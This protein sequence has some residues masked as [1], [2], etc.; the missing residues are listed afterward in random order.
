MPLLLLLT[1]L[2]LSLITDGARSLSN[3]DT[4][5]FLNTFDPATPGLAQLR[6]RL[7]GAA[8]DTQVTG[9]EFVR[10]VETPGSADLEMNWQ[11]RIVR[12]QGA[13]AT[14]DLRPRVKCRIALR[15]GGMRIVAFE[16][17]DLF[18]APDVSGAWAAVASAA[19]ALDAPEV[20]T[21]STSSSR[22]LG[23]VQLFDP[24]MPGFDQL[25]N[26]VAGLLAR[27]DVDLSVDLVSNEGDDR[28]RTIESEWTLDLVDSNTG[29]SILRRT[30]SI[31]CQVAR[32]KQ[33]WRIV[34]LD[35]PAFFAPP[36]SGK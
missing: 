25:R 7:S 11:V 4:A 5:A 17:L 28:R 24:A 27:G 15:D 16:P 31:V 32:R 3:G 2:P 9:I 12:N 36:P 29:I 22:L 26:N 21:Q 20:S 8:Y 13:P 34:S 23:F 14:I 30:G 35:P 1:I 18:A 10:A 19:S 6:S 33:D